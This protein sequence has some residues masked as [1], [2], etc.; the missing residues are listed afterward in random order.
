[1]ALPIY[2]QGSPE[3][4]YNRGSKTGAPVQSRGGCFRIWSV[5]IVKSDKTVGDWGHEENECACVQVRVAYVVR[6]MCRG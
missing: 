4:K 5:N 3:D 1:M 6:E 2:A